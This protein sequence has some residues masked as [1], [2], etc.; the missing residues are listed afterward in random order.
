MVGLRQ[1]HQ[2]TLRVFYESY[3]NGVPVPD[4]PLMKDLSIDLMEDLS[5][6]TAKM[7]HSNRVHDCAMYDRLAK[8]FEW[9]FSNNLKIDE[10]YTHHVECYHDDE[11]W[12]KC[13]HGHGEYE[14]VGVGEG[15]VVETENIASE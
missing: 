5:M 8:L 4:D 1:C 3:T 14:C 2:E 11:Y 6:E 12:T 7:L 9:G 15:H 13:C 10:V